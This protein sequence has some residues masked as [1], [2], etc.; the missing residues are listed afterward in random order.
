[1]AVSE[2]QL[3]RELRKAAHVHMCGE[4][5][6]RKVYYCHDARQCDLDNNGRCHACRG[7]RVPI[8]AEVL[9]P[10]SCCLTNTEVVHTREERRRYRLAGPGPWFRCRACSRS[11]GWPPGSIPTPR[12]EDE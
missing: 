10:K 1:M 3:K 6:C 7:I 4:R 5:T 9:D 8:W 11:N 12:G 2:A